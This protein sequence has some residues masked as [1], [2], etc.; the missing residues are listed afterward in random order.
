ML[1]GSKKCNESINAEIRAG[2]IDHCKL[3]DAQDPDEPQNS[4]Q[5]QFIQIEG[6]FRKR[7]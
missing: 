5:D 1:P 2:S 7:K 4:Y 3:Q 6:S